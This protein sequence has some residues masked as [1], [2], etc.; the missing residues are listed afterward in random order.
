MFLRLILIPVSFL[1]VFFSTQA[2]END[3]SATRD[4][5]LGRWEL[6]KGFRNERETE[7]LAGVFFL[8]GDDG[9]MQTNLPVGAEDPTEFD[10]KKN[11]ILQKSPQPL[12]YSIQSV[13]DSTLVLTMEMRGVSFKLE[14]QR[15]AEPPEQQPDTLYNETQ[16]TDSL[17]E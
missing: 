10:I 7:M 9:K 8:F 11:E 1:T 14:L 13:T 6:D 15:A 16:P 5:I 4:A 2:C 3:T 17:S 12:T